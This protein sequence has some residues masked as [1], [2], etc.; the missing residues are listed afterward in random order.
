MSVKERWKG[1]TP[2]HY[3]SSEVKVLLE[4]LLKSDERIKIAYIF[5]SRVK[6]DNPLSD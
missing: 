4:N 5:G 3:A 2:I 6:K 1:T